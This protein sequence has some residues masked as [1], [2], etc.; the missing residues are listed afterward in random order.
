MEEEQMIM[1]RTRRKFDAAFKAKVA[2]EAVK[3][4]KTASQLASEFGVH[5]NLISQWKRQLMHDLPL[6]FSRN[7]DKDKGD[8]EALQSELYKQIGQ[9]K[10]EVDFLKKKSL[11]FR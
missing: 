6:I 7:G 1:S 8:A 2:L 3:N 10:V 5:P 9:L 11:M 4:E